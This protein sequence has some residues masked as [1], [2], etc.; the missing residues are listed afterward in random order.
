MMRFMQEPEMIKSM[1]V[2]D[3]MM[4]MVEMGLIHLWLM[5]S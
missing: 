4:K 1:Q 2:L 3:Q 5:K